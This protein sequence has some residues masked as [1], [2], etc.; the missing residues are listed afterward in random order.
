MQPRAP[1]ITSA[2]R[3]TA[4]LVFFVSGAA[5]GTLRRDASGSFVQSISFSH[6]LRICNAYPFEN[7]PIDIT[8]GNDNVLTAN[9]PLEYK[10]CRDFR[11]K[12]EPADRLQF[13][14]GDESAGTF[15]IS[16]LP[17]SDAVLLLVIRR[18]DP[19]TTAVSFESHVFAGTKDAQIAIIDAYKGPERASLKIKDFPTG[20]EKSRTEELRY[21][22]VIAVNQGEYKVSLEDTKGKEKA[23]GDLVAL[24]GEAY[25]IIRTGVKADQGTSY[26]ESLIVYP[27]SDAS[28]LRS[29][30]STAHLT[31]ALI[32]PTFIAAWRLAH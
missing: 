28:T 5:A 32:V 2:S 20:S 10:E 24:N 11:V 18:H 8:L 19:L 22:S 23:T 27:K 9:S 26:P 4:L 7:T 1:L 15:S 3:F 17:E 29:S 6:K 14:I 16:D 21:Q 13:T 25:V 12:L 31:A 30:A